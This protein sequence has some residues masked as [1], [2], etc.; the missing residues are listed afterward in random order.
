MPKTHKI[1]IFAFLLFF[2]AVVC[3]AIEDGFGPA[4]KL[5][6]KYFIAHYAPQLSASDLAQE[7]DITSSDKL[8]AGRTRGKT[9]SPEEEL[10]D[11]LDTLYLRVCNILDMHLYTFKVNIKICSDTKQLVDIYNYLFN[12]NSKD[13]RSYYINDL[14]TI[15]ISRENFKYGILG[16][17]IAHA[18]ISHYFV[19]QPPVAVAEVLAGYVEYQLRKR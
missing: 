7:L 14:N 3:W 6:G 5:E 16:H 13:L 18:V 17:E 8:L 15:Y 4:K 10:M 9:F 2:H 11:M 12:E 1:I 19:V